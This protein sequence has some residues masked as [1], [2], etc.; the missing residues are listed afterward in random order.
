VRKHFSFINGT[1][2]LAI[3]T[4]K[5]VEMLPNWLA[6]EIDKDPTLHNRKEIV[7]NMLSNL[8]FIIAK[9]TLKIYFD[10][11]PKPDVG[12]GEVIYG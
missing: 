10:R 7:E 1:L 5:G 12:E 9:K 3:R 8:S 11:L 4:T 2:Y 6:R